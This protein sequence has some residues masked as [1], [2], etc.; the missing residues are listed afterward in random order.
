M[1][2]TLGVEGF[3]EAVQRRWIVPNYESGELSVNNS[4]SVIEDIRNAAKEDYNVGDSVTVV[5]DGQSYTGV[6]QK[7]GQ[8]G[9]Y[10][11]S[12]KDDNKP[13]SIR[14]YASEELSRTEQKPNEPHPVTRV[15]PGSSTLNSTPL[16]H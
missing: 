9:K 16:N 1:R 4:A 12:F 15:N 11:I 7:V 8:Q 13:K 6:V 10:T 2:Q 3:A 5:D 14:E